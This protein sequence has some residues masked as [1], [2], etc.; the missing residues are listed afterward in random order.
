MGVPDRNVQKRARDRIVLLVLLLVA[1]LEAGVLAVTNEGCYSAS[2]RARMEAAR[3]AISAI[4]TAIDT[5][6][7]VKKRLPESLDE[8]TVETADSA[9]LL[10]KSMC[11][12]SWGHPFQ[13]KKIDQHKYEVR[14]SGADRQMGTADDLTN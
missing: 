8:L 10:N 11:N 3:A 4:S 5:F 14:S 7:T 9:A 13:Y 2:D 1:V 12:D 6:H